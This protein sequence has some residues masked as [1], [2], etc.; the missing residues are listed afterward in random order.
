V[1]LY[2]CYGIKQLRILL[3]I[4]TKGL[5]TLCKLPFGTFLLL[6]IIEIIKI[7]KRITVKHNNS[8][9]NAIFRFLRLN[10]AAPS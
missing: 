4:V 8:L 3:R 6:Y 9:I 7:R 5:S 2:P 10:N 1:P